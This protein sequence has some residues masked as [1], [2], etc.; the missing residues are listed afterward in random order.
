[1]KIAIGSKF[2]EGPYGGGNSFIKNLSSYLELKG[3]KVVNTLVDRD[4]DIM[5][6]TNPLFDSEHTTFNHLD[7]KNYQTKVN[8]LALSVQRINECD[9]RKNTN[10]VNKGIINSN[11]NIDHTVFVSSWLKDL[12]IKKGIKN[13]NISVILAGADS[14]IFN[15]ISKRKWDG[16]TK[17]K[18]VTHHW[19]DNWMK[20]FG[21]YQTID[22]MLSSK[23]WSDRLSFTYIGN[24]PKELNFK[25]TNLI[26]P[27]GNRE[28]AEELKKHHIYITGSLNEPSGNHHIEA[29]QCKLPVLY[30]DSGGISEYCEKYGLEYDRDSL[31]YKLNYLIDNYDAYYKKLENYD[32]SADKMSKE[33]LDLFEKLYAIK[34]DISENRQLPS[35]IYTYSQKMNFQIKRLFNKTSFKFKKFFSK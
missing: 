4:I 16:S 17:I 10:H 27:L 22:E 31:A 2:I 30:I 6:L 26:K 28:L 15:S 20:G 3:H 25:N 19:S 9:E 14:K 8:K 29:F 21:I 13:K 1:M 12:Y 35:S 18:L 7:I 32:L 23:K 24:Y 34:N 33:F 5:L 11:I